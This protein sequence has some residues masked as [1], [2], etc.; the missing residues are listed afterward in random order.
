MM[1][2]GA[3]HDI[4]A[5]VHAQVQTAALRT[6]GGQPTGGAGRHGAAVSALPAD[7]G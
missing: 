7:D 1:R 5:V 6:D 4:G 2:A 3:V